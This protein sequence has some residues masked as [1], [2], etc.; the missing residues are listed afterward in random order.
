MQTALGG[1]T[2]YRVPAILLCALSL[3]PASD[4]APVPTHLMPPIPV[5]FPITSG[6][7]WVYVSPTGEEQVIEVVDV[8]REG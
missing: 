2:V 7:K 6:A 3:S 5:Y 1:F 8:K 4:A